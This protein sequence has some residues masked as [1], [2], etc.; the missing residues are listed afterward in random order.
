MAASEETLDLVFGEAPDAVLVAGAAAHEGNAS[1]IDY[2]NPAFTALAGWPAEKLLG[3]PLD[4]LEPAA[5]AVPA[6]PG[7]GR[8]PMLLRRPDGGLLPVEVARHPIRDAAGRVRQT[9]HVLHVPTGPAGRIADLVPA[10]VAVVRPDLGLDYANRAFEDWFA[11]RREDV[12]GRPLAEIAGPDLFARLRPDLERARAGLPAAGRSTCIL[13]DGQWR[14]L[15]ISCRPVE[16]RPGAVCAVMLDETEAETARRKADAANRTKSEFLA[17][18]S[19]ELRT[20]LNAVMGF[21]EMIRDELLGPAGHP[22]YR[23]Y[24]GDILASGRH[25]LDL[26]SDLIDLGRIET[27]KV[28]TRPA[29]IDLAALVEGVQRLVGPEARARSISMRACVPAGLPALWADERAVR[30]IL[31][32]LLS[33]AV[34]YGEAGGEA[35][36]SARPV[37]ADGM[38]EI[39]VRD[40]GIGMRQEDLERIG[41]PY[42]RLPPEPGTDP[43]HA[44]EGSGIGLYVTKSLIEMNGGTIAFESRPGVGTTVRVRLPAAVRNADR[45]PAGAPVP[46]PS[47]GPTPAPRRAAE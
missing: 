43:D 5:G 4:L 46:A 3:R 17:H 38:V 21:A 14:H 8:T 34:K 13:P 42:L 27:G 7:A 10:A 22:K 19:H 26:V 18:M 41:Q 36:L 12:V 2:V 16:D 39:A 32:N 6:D 44:R 45:R 35:V 33:N 20:P 40:T 15:R 47:P 1:A 11:C 25:L 31:L 23:D 30:Q 37:E 28:E 24:A 9:V 29:S